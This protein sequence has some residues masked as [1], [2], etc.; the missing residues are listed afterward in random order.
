MFQEQRR[1]SGT[2]PGVRRFIDA[3]MAKICY[4]YTTNR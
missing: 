1:T 4:L 2:E 3:G